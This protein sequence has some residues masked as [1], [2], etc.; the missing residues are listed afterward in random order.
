MRFHNYTFLDRTF[1][2]PPLSLLQWIV[3][4]QGTMCIQSGG[5]E[6][7]LWWTQPLMMKYRNVWSGKIYPSQSG[8]W[9]TLRRFR[10]FRNS[11]IWRTSFH[12][13]IHHGPLFFCLEEIAFGLCNT[14]PSPCPGPDEEI[15]PSHL[16]NPT[17]CACKPCGHEHQLAAT[18]RLFKRKLVELTHNIQNIK[19]IGL[20]TTFLTEEGLADRDLSTAHPWSVSSH[21]EESP[22]PKVAV[23]LMIFDGLGA[24][25]VDLL[26]TFW[27]LVDFWRPLMTFDD[28]WPF[29][30]ILTVFKDFW[31]LFDNFD[32]F[33][34]WRLK[35]V[36]WPLALGHTIFEIIFDDFW[37]LFTI[38]TSLPTFWLFWG[39][40]PMFANYWRF[41][42]DFW[43][44]W[45]LFDDFGRLVMIFIMPVQR[46]N[47]QK[48]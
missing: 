6:L 24:V 16:R 15:L 31:R 9:L 1:P 2:R 26:L 10:E 37:L 27:R 43:R 25:F 13:W 14:L 23:P 39:F 21:V 42:Y 35:V 29:L 20:S 45:R 34:S 33:F 36:L 19:I 5:C 47:T 18:M 48:T 22:W 28:L 44:F 17:W 4:L 41:V 8:K 38:V 12:L 3:L 32:Y 11:N 40:L 46:M 7:L 30:T